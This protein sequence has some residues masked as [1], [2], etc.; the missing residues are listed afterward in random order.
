MRLGMGVTYA[1]YSAR[2]KLHDR[3][4]VSR[5]FVLLVRELGVE[6]LPM[7]R[8]GLARLE[9]KRDGVVASALATDLFQASPRVSDHETGEL[10]SRYLHGST[11]ELTSA[12]ADSLVGFW[13]PRATPF[14]L[15][16][17]GSHDDRVVLTAIEGLRELQMVVV[18][19]SSDSSWGVGQRPT[20]AAH[21]R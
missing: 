20:T 3:A 7:V 4:G 21:L 18:P 5:R 2:L 17:L 8:A 13:G 6:A 12:A 16:L 15:G 19:P 11:P 9:P 14:M 1:L 10:A